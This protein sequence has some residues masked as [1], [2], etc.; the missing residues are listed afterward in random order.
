MSFIFR[1]FHAVPFA[2]FGILD[3]SRSVIV[4]INVHMSF[5]LCAP[6][7]VEKETKRCAR[8]V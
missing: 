6:V 8:L 7:L 3:S 4:L 5:T 1:Y 2:L